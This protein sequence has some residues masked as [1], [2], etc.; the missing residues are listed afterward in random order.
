MVA[1]LSLSIWIYIYIFFGYSYSLGFS[2]TLCTGDW[3]DQ[4]IVVDVIDTDRF[5]PLSLSR[6]SSVSPSSIYCFNSRMWTLTLF[7]LASK[8]HYNDAGSIKREVIKEKCFAFCHF[9]I[10]PLGYLCVNCVGSWMDINKYL[11]SFNPIRWIKISWMGTNK[12][13]RLWTDEIRCFLN[14]YWIS[15]II[16]SALIQLGGLRLVGWEQ[17]KF[18]DYELVRS[19]AF[20]NIYYILDSVMES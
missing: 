19:D 10:F 1:S 7:W 3:N 20:L 2:A 9:P 4:W 5:Y 16:C 14:I 11:L 17:T 15:I 13:Y 8:L 6:P 12:V 18:I